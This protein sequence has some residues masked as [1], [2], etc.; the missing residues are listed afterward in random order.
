MGMSQIQT[1]FSSSYN[2]HC[3]PLCHGFNRRELSVGDIVFCHFQR[4]SSGS[5][6]PSDVFRFL[7]E[8]RVQCCQTQQVRYTQRVDYLMQ[9]PVPLEAAS[10]RGNTFCN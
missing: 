4:N 2:V 8:E 9:L 7:V 5:E 10:N 6:N 1:C 3:Y